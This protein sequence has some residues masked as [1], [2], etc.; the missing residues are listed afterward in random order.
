MNR[1][2]KKDNPGTKIPSPLV[3]PTRQQPRKQGTKIS[4]NVP[5]NPKLRSQMK[6]VN[7]IA[8]TSSKRRKLK[9]E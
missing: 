2:K 5:T 9:G 7:V 3:M 6:K 1:K 8:S 4:K